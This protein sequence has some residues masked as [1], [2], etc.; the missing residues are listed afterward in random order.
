[1]TTTD[2]ALVK[3][4]ENVQVCLVLH[5]GDDDGGGGGRCGRKEGGGRRRQRGFRSGATV[6]RGAKSGLRT[7]GLFVV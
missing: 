2:E 3:N 7:G 5:G 1:M 4:K 6:D